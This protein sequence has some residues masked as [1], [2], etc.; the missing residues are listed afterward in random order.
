MPWQFPA[1]T[2]PVPPGFGKR[3]APSRDEDAVPGRS[4]FWITLFYLNRFSGLTNQSLKARIVPQR[5]PPRKQ[6]QLAVRN[7]AGDLQKVVQL[8]QRKIFLAS[9][10]MDN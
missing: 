3:P 9:P 8:F 5:I 2:A 7:R 4:P 1:R 6:T 10:G